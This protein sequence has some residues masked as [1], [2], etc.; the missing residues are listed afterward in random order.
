[1]QHASYHVTYSNVLTLAYVI[2]IIRIVSVCV[3][4]SSGSFLP[5]SIEPDAF[6]PL[7]TKTHLTGVKMTTANDSRETFLAL[8]DELKKAYDDLSEEL[9]KER[10]NAKK[11]HT[12]EVEIDRVRKDW[13]EALKAQK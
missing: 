13:R 4:K 8:T 2:V 1:M 12:L 5:P 3:C 6:H 7:A 11:L 10:I 9:Q